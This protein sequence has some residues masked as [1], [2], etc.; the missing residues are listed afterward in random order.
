MR[1][2][3]LLVG[4]VAWCALTA[5]RAGEPAEAG[6]CGAGEGQDCGDEGSL[7]QIRRAWPRKPT[8]AGPAEAQEDYKRPKDAAKIPLEY[9]LHDVPSY[10]VD[11]QGVPP[12]GSWKKCAKPP[13]GT[14]KCPRPPCSSQV[15]VHLGGP[16]E[17]VVV[18]LANT[19]TETPS[20]V[21]YWK[22]GERY[23]TR[24]GAGSA[25]TYSALTY[26]TSDWLWG[27]SPIPGPFDANK[28]AIAESMSTDDW[29][30]YGNDPS[31]HVPHLWEVV[32]P[33]DVGKITY[34]GEFGDY[35]N[36]K[37]WYTSPQVHTVVLKD[38]ADGEEYEYQV[39]NND[40]VF[41]FK[42]PGCAKTY[43]FRVGL[44]SDVGQTS[45][46]MLSMKQVLN[47]RVDVALMSGDLSYADGYYLRWD[48]WGNL[49]QPL[50]SRI[51]VMMCPG[52]HEL[53]YG[54]AFQ[55][56]NARFPMPHESSGSKNPNYWSRNIGPMHVI[57]LNSY[58]DIHPGS[59]QYAWLKRD[60][61][62][63]FTR[64]I[65][66]YLVV[67]MHV[68]FYSSTA[69]HL[70]EGKVA[71]DVLEPLFFKHG[72][73]MV[74]N[75][76]THAYERT[77]P[78]YRNI[79]NECGPVYFNVGDGGNHEGP[80]KQW[81]PGNGGRYRPVWSAFRQNSFGTGILVLQSD[82]TAKW[83]FRR[84]AC[85]DSGKPDFDRIDCQ[86][87]VDNSVDASLPGELYYYK[88]PVDACPNQK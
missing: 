28:E 82:R 35:K 81:L 69:T 40:E 57:S 39:P 41:R 10:G 71:R 24:V 29:A 62:L 47:S 5:T 59:E 88:R 80:V 64:S 74:F 22:S 54:E 26:Y 4:C 8:A 53:A 7:A 83:E 38:L 79:T 19:T 36:P 60:L 27:G 44:L 31:R 85:Y 72:V 84:N 12:A 33:E 16:G 49:F 23:R 73:N 78:T 75:G 13:C 17:M 34:P 70:M 2:P 18:Y 63:V 3:G 51:P 15:H 67:M 1:A 11:G 65:T 87:E 21:Q 43:P 86:T 25:R 77:T 55:T 14:L 58:A 48:S 6:V 76:H 61:E 32:T 68:P 52:N 66:P 37:Q 42:M 45:V 46:S 20:T 50:G 56:Y 9:L 30:Y